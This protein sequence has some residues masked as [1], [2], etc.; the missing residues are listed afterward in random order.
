MWNKIIWYKY[1]NIKLNILE[2]VIQII[3]LYRSILDSEINIIYD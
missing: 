3:V 1:F 2:I